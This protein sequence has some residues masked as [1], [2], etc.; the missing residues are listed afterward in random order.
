[1]KPKTNRENIP[2]KDNT[3]RISFAFWQGLAQIF[4]YFLLAISFIKDGLGDYFVPILLMQIF[5]ICLCAIMM[6]F[7]DG[8]R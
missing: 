7:E 8:K 2:K 6:L 3:K 4:S 5:M 1:M